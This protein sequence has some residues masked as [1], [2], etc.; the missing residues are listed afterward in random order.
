MCVFVFD[1]LPY[2]EHLDYVRPENLAAVSGDRER[3][4]GMTMADIER[5]AQHMP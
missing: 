5:D 1:F 2:N 3:F 4:H